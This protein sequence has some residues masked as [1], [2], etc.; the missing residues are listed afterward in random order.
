MLSGTTLH[1]RASPGLVLHL[2]QRA[3]EDQVSMLSQIGRSCSH[4][5]YEVPEGHGI[6][7]IWSREALPAER[8]KKCRRVPLSC[9]LTLAP[10]AQPWRGRWSDEQ[11]R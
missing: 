11:V 1:L 2:A 7:Q 4:K 5:M 3:S 10:V 9:Y 6:R 8:R